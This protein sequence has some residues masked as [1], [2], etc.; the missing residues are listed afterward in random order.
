MLKAARGSDLISHKQ[1]SQTAMHEYNKMNECKCKL[2]TNT[3]KS[4][5]NDTNIIICMYK[6]RAFGRGNETIQ[7]LTIQV[8]I[9]WC[10]VSGISFIKSTK[11]KQLEYT[12]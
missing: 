2:N 4:K 8:V 5:N 11:F 3:N 6:L 10:C 12:S 7:I 1:S 9:P